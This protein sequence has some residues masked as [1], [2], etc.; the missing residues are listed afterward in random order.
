MRKHLKTKVLRVRHT[1]VGLQA[2]GS[3]RPVI[4]AGFGVDPIQWYRVI[5]LHMKSK[6]GREMSIGALA[7]AANVNVQTIRYYERR[8]LIPKADRT[9]GGYRRYT[10][11]SVARIRFI[12]RAQ[13]LGFS[14]REIAD[15][16]S[17]RVRRDTAC[18][19]VE[20]KASSKIS[21]VEQKIGELETIRS[22]LEALVNACHANAVTGDCP[23][24]ETLE[25]EPVT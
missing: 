18:A 21:L 5:T 12:K 22:A 14:L 8:A 23:I 15:L 24:I 4:A 16:L 3:R 17:L 20:A 2:C 19:E 1:V 11:E 9:P 6:I 13:D 25:R 10:E 7:A